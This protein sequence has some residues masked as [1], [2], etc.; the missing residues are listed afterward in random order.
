[1][2]DGQRGWGGG[3]DGRSKPYLD[4]LDGNQRRPGNTLTGRQPGP[5]RNLTGPG[6]RRKKSLANWK[7]WL[8]FLSGGAGQA[9]GGRLLS[10]C[11]NQSSVSET[12]RIAKHHAEGGVYHHR[13]FAGV[14]TWGLVT[15]VVDVVASMAGSESGSSWRGLMSRGLWPARA[16]FTRDEWLDVPD[17]LGRPGTRQTDPAAQVPLRQ[18]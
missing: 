16:Q 4:G 13:N 6:Q 9:R 5:G 17:P 10:R 12:W 15:A 1:M 11:Q 2:G 7:P 14:F 3:W 8:D 18:H